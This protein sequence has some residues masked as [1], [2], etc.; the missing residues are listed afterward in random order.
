MADGFKIADAYVEVHLK[1]NTK[2]GLAALGR[3]SAGGIQ[4]PITPQWDRGKWAAQGDLIGILLGQRISRSTRNV[5]STGAK[6]MMIGL[7][8]AVMAAAMPAIGGLA[9]QFGVLELATYEA[10]KA[11]QAYEV[12]LTTGKWE[13]WNRRWALMNQQQRE[14]VNIVL[15]EV[16]PAMKQLRDTASKTVLP[17]LNDALR[18]AISMLPIFSAAVARTG[19]E[20]SITGHKFADLFRNESFRRNMDEYL[21]SL[22]VV[23]RAVGDT[24]VKLT[25]KIVE[26][27][28]RM[29]PAT[30]GFANFITLVGDGFA[31]AL[32][33]LQPYA[34]DFKLFFESVGRIIKELL[35]HIAKLGGEVV[36]IL[37]PAFSALAGFLE[38]NRDTISSL[39]PLVA[40]LAVAFKGL[41]ILHSITK[42]GSGV[43]AL[44][45]GIGRSADDA[46]KK[47]DATG[48]KIG[49][50]K[51]LGP[52]GITIA[53]LGIDQAIGA[54][55]SYAEKLRGLPAENRSVWDEIV[56]ITA[57]SAKLMQE[58][59]FGVFNE[60]FR[61]KLRELF[62]GFKGEG[63]I[64][65]Q[66]TGKALAD[67]AN[68]ELVRNRPRL[69]FDFKPAIASVG[70]AVAAGTRAKAVGTFDANNNPA[71]TKIQGF[72]GAAGRARGI[73]RLDLDTS[74]AMSRLRAFLAQR[75]TIRVGASFGGRASGGA[76]GGLTLV[77]EH[78][79]ELVKVPGMASGG[80]MRSMRMVGVNGPEVTSLPR[81]STVYPTGQSAQML[82]QATSAAGG[83]S[84]GGAHITF[85]GNTDG[86]FATAFM[87]LVREGK[88]QVRTT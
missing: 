87:R 46:G 40:A 70:T 85:G 50:L 81:G 36:Q 21:K 83:G 59:L 31:N 16:G 17:G 39:I 86:A 82:K 25:D 60:D 56:I 27:A 58:N 29:K 79:P 32:T 35:P 1:D 73:A 54:L 33:T 43:A 77:G 65:G 10:Q 15:H 22:D 76:S 52:I 51:S 18:G 48:K 78:G 12:G 37:G 2:G 42:F 80:A 44:F 57:D 30:E 75:P 84:G 47:V 41:S 23:H 74:A 14:F 45:S 26:T 61:A 55:D 38:R 19:N 4:A 13:E 6:P 72:V 69:D 71:L 34:A 53:L 9:V 68:H 88:I 28:A 7:R 64:A 24:A 20:I 5:L 67:A 8:N 62:G 49:G 11:L 66:E 63:H 3:R